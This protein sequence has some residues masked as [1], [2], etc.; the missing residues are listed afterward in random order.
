MKKLDV[1]HFLDIYTMR[2]NMQENGI[3]NPSENIK[4]FTREFVEKLEN[5]P[6]HE[7]II[8]KDSSFFDSLGNLIIK[9]PD[10]DDLQKDL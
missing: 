4:K 8:L 10:I 7:E 9:F 3:T 6:L 1:E 5:M 2:K